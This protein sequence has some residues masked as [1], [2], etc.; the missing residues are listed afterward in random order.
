MLSAAAAAANPQ[1]YILTSG[2]HRVKYWDQSALCVCK[3]LN[4]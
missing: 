2:G 3:Y 4:V 1:A